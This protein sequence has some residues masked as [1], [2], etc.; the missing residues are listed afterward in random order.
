MKLQ[1]PLLG[2]PVE[3]LTLRSTKFTLSFLKHSF[4]IL[5]ILFLF[6]LCWGRGAY[7]YSHTKGDSLLQNNTVGLIAH[8]SFSDT[9]AGE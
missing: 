1:W 6:T 3:F 7:E 8:L 2:H 9:R 4:L 5:L